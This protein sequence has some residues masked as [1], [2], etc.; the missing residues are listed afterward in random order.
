MLKSTENQ[1][2][3]S[4]FSIS[5]FFFFYFKGQTSMIFLR[6]IQ[7]YAFFS[8][9]RKSILAKFSRELNSLQ[10]CLSK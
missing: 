4:K 6:I 2:P 10:K 9:S 5:S 8:H 1:A 7:R 3:V